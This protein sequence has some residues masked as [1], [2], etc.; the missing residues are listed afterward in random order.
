MQGQ[1]NTCEKHDFSVEESGNFYEN[2]DTS[3]IETINS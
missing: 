3:R 1:N 2:M